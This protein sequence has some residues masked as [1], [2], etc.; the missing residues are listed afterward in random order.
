[1]DVVNLNVYHYIKSASN[2]HVVDVVNVVNVIN[3]VVRV[4]KLKIK[5]QENGI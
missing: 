1:V 5:D 2:V 4:I 3:V